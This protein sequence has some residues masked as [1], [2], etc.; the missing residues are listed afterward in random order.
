MSALVFS[1]GLYSF[2]SSGLFCFVV[3]FLLKSLSSLPQFGISLPSVTPSPVK[4]KGKVG[5]P[6]AS[7]ASKEKTPSPKEDDEEPD[8]PP[9]KKTSASPVP[10]KSGDEGS[11]DEAPSGED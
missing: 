8:S 4:G 2:Y 3:D 10:E 5:R 6:T 1:N 11:E 7:K 9:E